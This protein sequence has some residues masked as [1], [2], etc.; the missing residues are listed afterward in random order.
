MDGTD[1]HLG[2]AGDGA[3]GFVWRTRPIGEGLIGLRDRHEG[4]PTLEAVQG[5]LPSLGVPEGA[6]RPRVRR[7]RFNTTRLR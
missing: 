2:G 3:D 5:D 6:D 4:Q 1:G 7:G